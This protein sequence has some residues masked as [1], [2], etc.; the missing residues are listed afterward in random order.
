MVRFMYCIHTATYVWSYLLIVDEINEKTKKFVVDVYERFC[1]MLEEHGYDV[2]REVVRTDICHVFFDVLGK[3]V[4]SFT[5]V[6]GKSVNEV[7]ED[8]FK[9]FVEHESEILSRPYASPIVFI[10]GNGFT[11]IYDDY[12]SLFELLKGL[13]STDKRWIL[14]DSDMVRK[15][16][17]MLM[18]RGPVHTYYSFAGPKIYVGDDFIAFHWVTE[19][20]FIVV[21]KRVYIEEEYDEGSGLYGTIPVPKGRSYSLSELP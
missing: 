5:E 11:P 14:V 9:F 10:Y 12:K 7:A 1:K 18:S 2:R 17:K 8:M 13:F 15:Y 21:T 20:E 16:I 6:S 19:D 4:Y 3:S